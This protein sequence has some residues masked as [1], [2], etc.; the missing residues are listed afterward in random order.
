MGVFVVDVGALAVGIRSRA[1]HDLGQDP[2]D[3]KAKVSG[4]LEL[5][6]MW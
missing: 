1:W 4:A 2:D 3:P 6:L 5:V